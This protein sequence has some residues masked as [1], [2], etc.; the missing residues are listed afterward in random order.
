[1]TKVNYVSDL[2]LEFSQFPVKDEP[3]VD[4]TKREIKPNPDEYLL[5]A[6]DTILTVALKEKRTDGDARKL[7]KRFDRFCDIAQGFKQTYMVPGNHEAYS[8]GDVATNAEVVNEYLA[9]KNYTNIR[10]LENERVS[11]T[12]KVELLACTLWTSMDN[13][14]PVVEQYC[15]RGMNDFYVCN[16]KGAPFYASD[17]ADKHFE[18][19]RWL[20]GELLDISKSYVVMTHHL[21]SFQGIDPRFKGDYLNFAYASEMEDFIYMNPHILFWI[22]GHTHYDTDYMIGHTR[23]LSK[24]R[25]YPPQIIGNR[26]TNWKNFK[27]GSFEI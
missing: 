3:D 24:Q 8:H 7:Q 15:N 27:P 1:M 26:E 13:R 20:A 25:G 6:G 5:V 11:L 9:R 23:I 17:C 19:R 22:H 18:S 2:H 4:P 21:P 12:D 14:N 10:M 16:Y